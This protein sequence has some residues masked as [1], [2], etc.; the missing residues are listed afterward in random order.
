MDYQR[1]DGTE[2]TVFKYV[3]DF[4]DAIAEAV[5][6]RYPDFITRTVLCISTQSGC[7]CACSFCGSGGKFIRNLTTDEITQQVMTVFSDM[8]LEENTVITCGKL[9]I[10]FMS[11]G[12]PMLNFPSVSLAIVQ[13]SRWY[14]NAQLLLSTIGVDN[15]DTFASLIELS[16]ACDQ[17]GLQFSLHSAVDETR[18]ALIPFARKMPLRTL[19]DAGLLWHRATRRPVFLNYCVPAEG[20]GD[21]ERERILDLFSPAVF[22]LTFSVICAADETHKD[23]GVRDLELLRTHEAFFLDKGY[24]VRTFDPNGQ[25]DIGGGYGQLWYVQ[26]WM[27][28]HGR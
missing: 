22:A 4:G 9:Q 12:E 14:P 3:F 25:D 6:Y 1:F 24:N 7:P 10:M 16:V 20:I 21:E 11:M 26:Q 19:R 23:A 17:V 18:D 8:G 27:R 5:L 15:D 28:E 2:G 13:L